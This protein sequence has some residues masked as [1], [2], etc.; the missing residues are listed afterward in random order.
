MK[1]NKL[2]IVDGDLI[3][4]VYGGSVYAY[5]IRNAINAWIAENN[6]HRCR[7]TE[8]HIG[9]TENTIN[10]TVFSTADLFEETILK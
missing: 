3:I 6:F 4:I 1:L 5:D 10:I 2:K 9:G 8:S 7:I